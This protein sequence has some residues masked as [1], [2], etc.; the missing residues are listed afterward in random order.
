[1]CTLCEWVVNEV[2]LVY[3]KLGKTILSHLGAQPHQS[4][5]GMFSRVGT[6]ATVAIERALATQT[7]SF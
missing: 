5:C 4:K 2:N 3:D 1:M 6:Y 7:P